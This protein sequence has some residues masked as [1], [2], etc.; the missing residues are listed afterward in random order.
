LNT[1]YKDV[2][3]DIDGVPPEADN[4]LDRIPETDLA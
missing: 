1:L 2:E 3:E 4:Y